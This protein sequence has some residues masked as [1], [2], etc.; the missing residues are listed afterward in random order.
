MAEAMLPAELAEVT[1]P[2]DADDELLTA[3]ELARLDLFEE[4]KKQPSFARFPGTTV[5]RKCRKGRVLVRQGDAGATA[6]SILTTEDVIELREQQL[7]SV[8]KLQAARAAGD[9]ASGIHLYY[10]SLSD[11][12][13]SKRHASLTEEL[14]QLRDKA[15]ALQTAGTPPAKRHVATAHLIIGGDAEPKRGLLHRLLH[16]GR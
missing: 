7:E 1:D 11:R 4:L 3:D 10:E 14:Q 16:R 6:Y 5:L 12:D 13:L 2:L 8:E 15:A 9:A